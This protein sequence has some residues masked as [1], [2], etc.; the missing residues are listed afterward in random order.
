MTKLTRRDVLKAT[1][2]ASTAIPALHGGRHARLGPGA[3]RQR[4]L[5]VGV[6]GIGGRGGG[7]VDEF[8]R[9]PDVEIA[10][11]IDPDSRLFPRDEQARCRS[12][13][14]E[15]KC[16]QDIRV[17]LGR[18]RTSMPSAWPPAITGTR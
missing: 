18:T 17:A 3:G 16:V 12:L 13:I 1:A 5:R 7:H 10:Y 6:V 15:P 2:A 11:L 8:L 14:G 4:E 9:I